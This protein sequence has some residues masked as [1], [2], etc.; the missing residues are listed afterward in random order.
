[1]ISFLYISISDAISDA[2][3]AARF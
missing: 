1:M 3:S 2:F